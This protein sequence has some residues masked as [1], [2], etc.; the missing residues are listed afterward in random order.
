MRHAISQPLHLSTPDMDRMR[1]PERYWARACVPARYSSSLLLIKRQSD[2]AD[3]PKEVGSAPAC[4]ANL[5]GRERAGARLHPALPLLGVLPIEQYRRARFLGA[6]SEP[7]DPE[8]LGRAGARLHPALPLLGLLPVEQHRR[9]GLLGAR[10]GGHHRQRREDERHYIAAVLLC[11]GDAGSALD[12]SLSGSRLCA[13]AQAERLHARTPTGWA[14]C[15]VVLRWNACMG[16]RYLV[17]S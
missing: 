5:E 10:P 3:G 12:Q 8:G 14:T 7:E 2:C 16:C 17:I 9:A 13:G 1:L 11:R 6:R 15:S 4:K